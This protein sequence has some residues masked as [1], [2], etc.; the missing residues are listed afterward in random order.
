METIDGLFTVVRGGR[1]RDRLEQ[2]AQNEHSENFSTM[3]SQT[4]EKVTQRLCHSHPWSF[5]W[6]KPWSCSFGQQVGLETSWRI[7][8]SYEECWLL[9]LT[10]PITLWKACRIPGSLQLLPRSTGHT[11]IY[12]VHNSGQALLTNTNCWKRKAL[13][14]SSD[15]AAQSYRGN[16]MTRK[17]I[18]FRAGWEE[19]FLPVFSEYLSWRTVER[20]PIKVG[21]S[22]L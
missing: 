13:G 19:V 8:S 1:K 21:I 12:T 15:P 6:T 4:V 3:R 22:F 17:I 14:F 5:S 18:L 2:E 10:P 7:L 16:K 9:E 20:N 11:V